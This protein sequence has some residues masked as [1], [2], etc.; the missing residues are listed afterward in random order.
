MRIWPVAHLSPSPPFSLSHSLAHALSHR[1]SCPGKIARAT[2]AS[3]VMAL[4]RERVCE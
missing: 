3:T 2:V 1:C 4:V